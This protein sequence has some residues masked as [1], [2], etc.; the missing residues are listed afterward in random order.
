MEQWKDLQFLALKITFPAALVLLVQVSAGEFKWNVNKS[1]VAELYPQ[2][3]SAVNKF[4]CVPVFVLFTYFLSPW[5]FILY[6]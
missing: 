1:S 2:V 3:S 6:L 4:T 5:L